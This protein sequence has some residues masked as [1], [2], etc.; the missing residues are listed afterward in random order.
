M[1]HRRELLT[2]M[3]KL[4]EVSSTETALFHQVAA[5]KVGLGVTEMKT[6]SVLLQE[7][8]ASAGQIAARLNLTSGAVTGIIDRL[9]RK[10][11]VSRRP[12]PK[13]RRKIIVVLNR[14][15]LQLQNTAYHSMG[16]AFTELLEKYSTEEL[17]FLVRYYQATIELTKQEIAKLS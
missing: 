16:A 14:Q 5:S 2:L 15:K 1:N 12:D 13:D 3:Y 4:G 9:V 8:P 17:E 7:G 10:E 6:L 11:F